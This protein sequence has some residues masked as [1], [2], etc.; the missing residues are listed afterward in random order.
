QQEQFIVRVIREEEEA[1]LRTLE[2]GLKRI[3]DIIADSNG[4]ISGK[5]AFELFDTYGFPFDLTRLIASERGLTIDE[6]AFS[7]EMQKQKE[8]SR[9]AATTDAGDWIILKEGNSEFVGYYSLETK[10]NVLRYRKV[11]AKGKEVYQIVLDKTPFY[12]ESGGQVGDIGTLTP[13]SLNPSFHFPSPEGEG[14]RRADEAGEGPGVRLNVIDTKKENDLIIHFTET[15]PEHPEGEVIAQVDAEKRKKTAIHHSATHLV[16]ATLRQVLG[17]HVVQ[18][19]SLVIADYLRFDFSH[20]SKVTPEEIVQ[21]ERIVNEKIRQNIPVVIKQMPKEEALQSGAMALFGEKYGDTVR[22]VIIDPSASSAFGTF[23]QGRREAE[24]NLF[25]IELCGGT[26]VGATG[27]LGFFKITSETAVAAGVRRI[28]AVSG[29]A[30][31]HYINEQLQQLQQVKE[32]MKNPKDVLR[33][34]EEL[35]TETASLRKQVEKFEQEQLNTLRNTLVKKIQ[36]INGA[37]FVGEIVNVGSADAL[38]KLAFDL[39]PL[40]PDHVIALAAAIEGKAQV[41]VLLDEAIAAQKDLNAALTIKQRIAPL[42]KGGGGGQKT[43]ATA[44][45]QNIADLQQ[46][47]EAVRQLL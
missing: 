22:V 16:H 3:E 5:D 31:E 12:A 26:H 24:K 23:F 21:I 30:A 46:V 37:N 10:A 2:K 17:K 40:I 19:G 36:P 39:K 44:G 33:A 27:E 13:L 25:S 15:L 8:R 18:K 47:I 29:V 9:A 32:A 1:F 35:N 45:G 43:L 14:A 28:E 6:G 41:V 4:T 38:K 34:I 20:F 11:K 7:T 42:I